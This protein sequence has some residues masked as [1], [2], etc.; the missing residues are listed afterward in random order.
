MHEKETEQKNS[1]PITV[2][3]LEAVIRMSE[4]LAKMQLVPFAT[5]SHVEESL[6]LFQVSTLAAAV[7]GSLSCKYM[8]ISKRIFL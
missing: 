8:F 7:S 4:S 3:Q 6:R 2:R 5:I 1:I